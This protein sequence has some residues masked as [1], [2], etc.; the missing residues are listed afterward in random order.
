LITCSFKELSLQ[1][2]FYV[3]NSGNLRRYAYTSGETRLRGTGQVLMTYPSTG[4]STRSL[5]VSPQGDQLYVSVGSNSNVD[6]EYPPRAAVLV[7]KLDGSGNATFASGLRNSV[8]IDFHP[9]TGD[10]YV[11]VQERD[12]I[13]DDLVPD[14]FTRIQ[15]DQFYGWPFGM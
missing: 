10:L 5:V 6:I 11:A 4:H 12:Q 14:Y 7:A 8:G 3:A 13:G 9:K 2:W 1:G 15:K